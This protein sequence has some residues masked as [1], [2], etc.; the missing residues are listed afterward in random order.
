[1]TIARLPK[2][3]TRLPYSIGNYN[4]KRTV[5]ESDLSGKHPD[6]LHYRSR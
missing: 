4:L 5:D 2:H 1:M 6:L 3:H